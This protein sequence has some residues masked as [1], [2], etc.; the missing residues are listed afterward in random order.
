MTWQPGTA[1]E[2]TVPLLAYTLNSGHLLYTGQ[3]FLPLYHTK[4]PISGHLLT[5]NIGHFILHRHYHFNRKRPPNSG[6]SNWRSSPHAS[7]T[8]KAF[9]ARKCAATKLSH[10]TVN[11]R[12]R[13][14]TVSAS[15]SMVYC[16][17]QLVQ[18]ESRQF[19]VLMAWHC[20]SLHVSQVEFV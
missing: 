13:S 1:C 5:L 3:C 16:V 9:C 7:P 10:N 17:V 2:Y 19:I 12:K 6:H 11:H 15:F 8:S 20:N 14:T 18:W 4:P